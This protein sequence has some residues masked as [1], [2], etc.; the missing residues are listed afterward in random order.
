MD[1]SN[2]RAIS[3][4]AAI[5]PGSAVEFSE[6]EDEVR[7]MMLRTQPGNTPSLAVRIKGN[8]RSAN[9]NKR[10][11]LFVGGANIDADERKETTVRKYQTNQHRRK[12]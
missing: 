8:K 7:V 4:H 12:Q 6:G 5:G 11:A 2:G 9:A 10:L 1:L 3:L